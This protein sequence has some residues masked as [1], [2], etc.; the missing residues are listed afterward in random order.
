M[1]QE[2]PG[3]CNEA[4]QANDTSDGSKYSMQLLVA[5]GTEYTRR[6]A[7]SR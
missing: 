5:A 1:R 4:C 7:Y 3:D 6:P 2:I